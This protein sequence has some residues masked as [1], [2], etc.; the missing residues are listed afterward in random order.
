MSMTYKTNCD[1]IPE[2]LE[3]D[4]YIPENAT[5]LIIGTFPTVLKRRSFNF[6]YPNENNS[7]WNVLSQIAEIELVSAK[8]FDA[9]ENRKKILDK[10]QLGITDMGY[11]ILRHGSSSLDQSI[12]PIEFMNIFKILDENPKIQKL[13]LTSSS[14][15]NSVE[16]WLRSYCM[17]NSVEFLK[18]KGQNP[19][20]GFLKYGKNEIQVVSVHSTS[21]AAAR[22]IDDLI[23]MYSMEILY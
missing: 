20:R 3:W 11:K 23:E 10:L 22:K 19:K 12:F 4:S 15:V 17:L 2:T 1:I 21:K 6:F 8:Q 13:I 18:L 9:I 7:F 5:K 14:G 16:G